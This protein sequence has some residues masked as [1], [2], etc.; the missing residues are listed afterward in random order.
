MDLPD[1]VFCERCGAV[2]TVPRQSIDEDAE[3]GQLRGFDQAW[4][5][6]F[7]LMIECPNCGR[8]EQRLAE[9]PA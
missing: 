2:A 9:P 4:K 3:A 6:G 5:E 1:T 7:L 8:V